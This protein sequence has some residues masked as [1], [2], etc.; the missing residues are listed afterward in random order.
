MSI[1]IVI[2]EHDSSQTHDDMFL[3]ETKIKSNMFLGW[4]HAYTSLRIGEY[5]KT[6]LNIFFDSYVLLR[7]GAYVL[8][9]LVNWQIIL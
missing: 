1:N 5:N 9:F 4:K 6:S 8:F 7:V 3:H 2:L